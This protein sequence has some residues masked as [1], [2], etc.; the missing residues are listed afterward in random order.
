MT[1]EAVEMVMEN[2][3][4]RSREGSDRRLWRQRGRSLNFNPRS[5]EGSDSKYGQ[6]IS[7]KLSVLLNLSRIKKE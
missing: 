5:R 4:P 3:N 1:D 2:F 7:A 6:T